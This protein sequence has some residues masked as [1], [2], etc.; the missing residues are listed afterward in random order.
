[1]DLA[2]DR[3]YLYVLSSKAIEVYDI[4]DPEK[5]EKIFEYAEKDKK[6]NNILI[7]DSNLFVSYTLSS[8]EYGIQVFQIE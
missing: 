1:M 7:K 8:E 5:P 2:I 3:N 6:Y 4:K